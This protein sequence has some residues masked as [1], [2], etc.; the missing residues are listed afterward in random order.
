MRRIL[1]PQS[2]WIKLDELT[3]ELELSGQRSHS[4]ERFLVLYSTEYFEEL[5]YEEPNNRDLIRR[6][7]ATDDWATQLVEVELK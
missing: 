6:N 4:T 3:R 5:Q 1:P 2:D 7:L